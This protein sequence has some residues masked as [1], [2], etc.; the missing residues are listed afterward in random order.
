VPGRFAISLGLSAIAWGVLLVLRGLGPLE[1]LFARVQAWLSPIFCE[2]G[3]HLQAFHR[4]VGLGAP[5]A[6]AGFA[7]ALLVLYAASVI[8]VYCLLGI[9]WKGKQRARSAKPA[10]V[11]TF[12]TPATQPPI[13]IHPSQHAVDSRTDHESAASR[14]FVAHP[15]DFGSKSSGW[16]LTWAFFLTLGAVAVM[17]VGMALKNTWLV[18]GPWVVFFLGFGAFRAWYGMREIRICVTSDGLTV[19]RRPRE[20]FSLLDAKLGPWAVRGGM[21]VGT[22]LHLQSGP[23]QLVIGGRDYRL[24]TATPL[25]AP[26]VDTVDAWISASEFEQLLTMVSRRSGLKLRQPVPGE[27]TRCLLFPNDQILR[28]MAPWAYRDRARY[29]PSARQPQLA[30]DV[31]RDAIRV[32][33]PTT[34]RQIASASPA[35]VTTTPETY[36]LRRNKQVGSPSPVLVVAVPGVKPLTI[37][38]HERAEGMG[39]GQVRFSWRGKVPERTN[40]PAAYMVSGMDWLTLVEKCGFAAYL[41]DRSG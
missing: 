18:V 39:M 33:D 8:A 12:A 1:S 28:H 13:D 32:I 30:L 27:P 31:S 40:D 2:A 26:A 29:D 23:R 21:P 19:G 36:I 22:A 5:G 15:P 35:H 10:A 9:V 6:N 16:S 11:G 20:V 25:E 14:S 38:C 4:C 41:D 17:F 7:L 37:G 3:D 24:G 34:D